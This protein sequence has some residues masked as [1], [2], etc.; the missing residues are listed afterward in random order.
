V[1]DDGCGMT[2]SEIA[3]ALEPFGQVDGSLERRYDG[4]GLGLPLARRLIEL[5]AAASRSRARRAA[6][7]GH[8]RLAAARVVAPRPQAAS[9]TQR[10]AS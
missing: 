7:P 2:A 10:A 6:A 9:P 8:R 3:V 4:T 1:S 5:H